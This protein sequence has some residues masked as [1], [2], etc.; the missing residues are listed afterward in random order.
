MGKA[1]KANGTAAGGWASEED[2]HSEL[3]QPIAAAAIKTALDRLDNLALSL[4]WT[5][6]GKKNERSPLPVALPWRPPAFGT[7]SAGL[8]TMRA[9]QDS[10][11]P[12][13]S[14]NPNS[15]KGFWILRKAAATLLPVLPLLLGLAARAQVQSVNLIA[16]YGHYT[17]PEGVDAP[18][19]AFLPQRLTAD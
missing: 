15:S 14:Q 4:Q 10:L 16:Q 5:A 3:I 18:F 13:P 2:W 17:L 19:L 11:P 8:V 6:G 9:P 1:S 7:F 12:L